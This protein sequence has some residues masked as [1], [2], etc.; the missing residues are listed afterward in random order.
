M[1]EQC[2]ACGHHSFKDGRCTH[3]RCLHREIGKTEVEA[4]QYEEVAALAEFIAQRTKALHER[5]GARNAYLVH[6]YALLAV[7]TAAHREW[8][9]SEQAVR[10]MLDV[11][12]ATPGAPIGEA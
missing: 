3:L 2:R 7:A 12:L 9:T 8:G 6:L 4:L 1:T 11:L 5:V 10:Q